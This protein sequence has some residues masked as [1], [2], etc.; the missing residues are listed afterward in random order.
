M[1]RIC[2]VVQRYG[3]AIVGGSEQLARCYAQLLKSDFEVHVATTCATD[4][5]TWKNS[6]PAGTTMEH[7]IAVHRFSSDFERTPYFHQLNYQL[8]FRSVLSS[9][10]ELGSETGAVD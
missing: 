1:D 2:L 7:G 3:E 5:T 6:C 10:L 9:G 8:I 4:Y